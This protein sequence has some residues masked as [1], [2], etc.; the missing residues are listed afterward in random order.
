MNIYLFF[1]IRDGRPLTKRIKTN[2]P[3]TEDFIEE[4]EKNLGEDVHVCSFSKIEEDKNDF[5]NEEA[6]ND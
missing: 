5:I 4:L 3:I 6:K 2:K 1:F